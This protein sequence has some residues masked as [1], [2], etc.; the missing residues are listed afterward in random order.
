MLINKEQRMAANGSEWQLEGDVAMGNECRRGAL[1]SQTLTGQS[2]MTQ[3]TRGPWGLLAL[4]WLH[5]AARLPMVCP[6][7]CHMS[8]VNHREG[9]R[10]YASL[11]RLSLVS[12]HL[13]ARGV[14]RLLRE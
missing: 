1:R 14:T 8:R 5:I 12:Q 13:L 3:A 7:T 11:V 9:V 4:G 10:G 6:R 2:L